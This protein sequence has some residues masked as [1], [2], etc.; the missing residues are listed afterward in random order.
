MFLE[1]EVGIISAGLTLAGRRIC[2][3]IEAINLHLCTAIGIPIATFDYRRVTFPQLVA[4]LV[5][6]GKDMCIKTTVFL[7]TFPML[8]NDV[9]L[10]CVFMSLIVWIQASIFIATQFALSHL[11]PVAFDIWEGR[12]HELINLQSGTAADGSNL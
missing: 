11:S 3:M 9:E 5:F 7:Y 10:E 2:M 4:A 6:D 12:G 8:W 1:V